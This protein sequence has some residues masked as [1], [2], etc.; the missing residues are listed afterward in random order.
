VTRFHVRAEAVRGEHVSFD[1]DEA[2]HLARVMRLGPG[3]VVQAVDGQ[4]HELTVR[5][6]EVA[7]RGAH[8]TVVT[9]AVRPTESPLAL[10]LAQSIPKGDK[11]ERIIRMATELGVCRVVPLATE[12]TVVRVEASEWTDRLLRCRR[13]A[14]EAAKQ[15]GRAVIPEVEPPRSL[16]EWLDERE[17]RDLLVCFRE[18]ETSGLSALP[19]ASIDRMSVVVGPEGGWSDAEVARLASAGAVMAGLGPRILRAD[20]AAPI[21]LALIQARYGDIGAAR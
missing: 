3:D 1:A 2:R 5:I 7:P 8:G 11:L 13:V 10:T 12:R 6:T 9:R 18:G 20:T 16:A 15:C 4:G 21:A 17:S 19:A 14:R